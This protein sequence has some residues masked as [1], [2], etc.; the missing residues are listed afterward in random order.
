MNFFHE[1]TGNLTKIV[2]GLNFYLSLEL[3]NQHF[4]NL[5][6]LIGLKW[7]QSHRKPSWVASTWTGTV[8]LSILATFSLR[9]SR[10]GMGSFLR[11]CDWLSFVHCRL[12]VV[13]REIG[14][15]IK[16]IAWRCWI[17]FTRILT[18]GCLHWNS[19]QF[20]MSCSG[21]EWST[22]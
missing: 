15:G 21:S 19:Y 20:G 8:A 5:A 3:T 1:S 7:P 18:F 10:S 9:Y 22:S 11:C 12:L 2:K 16:A 17:L 14:Y 13:A 6:S 4:S